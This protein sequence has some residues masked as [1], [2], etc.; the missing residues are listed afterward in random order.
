MVTV[1]TSVMRRGIET[2]VEAN[3]G[4]VPTG[5]IALSL[6]VGFVLMLIIEQLVSP[7]AHS[8]EDLPMPM[9]SKATVSTMASVE[10]D[11]ELADLEQNERPSEHH[12]DSSSSGGIVGLG[13]ERAFTLLLGLVFHGCAD[14]LA[15]GVANLARTAP[16]A[17]NTVSFVVFLALILHKGSPGFSL[18]KICNHDVETMSY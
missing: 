16:G 3:P 13:R 15:L 7:N 18:F 14:G 11:A 6:I 5:R 9:Q 12:L 8:M 1:L 17:T 2:V 4:E 10:F